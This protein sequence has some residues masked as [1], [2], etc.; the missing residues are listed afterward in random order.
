MYSSTGSN[1]SHPVSGISEREMQLRQVEVLLKSAVALTWTKLRW[2]RQVEVLLK[3]A[4]AHSDETQVVQGME[5]RIT[6]VCIV[7]KY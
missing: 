6:R 2:V 3:S 7:S 5:S 4:V 1:D